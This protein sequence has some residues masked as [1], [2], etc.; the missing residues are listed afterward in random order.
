MVV[1]VAATTKP[2]WYRIP[3]WQLMYDDKMDWTAAQFDVLYG[4]VVVVV[5]YNFY[6]AGNQF[7]ISTDYMIRFMFQCKLALVFAFWFLLIHLQNVNWDCSGL[8]WLTVYCFNFNGIFLFESTT[9][10]LTGDIDVQICLQCPEIEREE[11]NSGN[12]KMEMGMATIWTD[13][14]QLPSWPIKMLSNNNER[15]KNEPN[16]KLIATLNKRQRRGK[17]EI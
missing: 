8:I 12:M 5:V 7:I 16:Q 15:C 17:N 11:K 6:S 13:F 3:R 10:H 4:H 2:N 9:L 14:Y 1:A